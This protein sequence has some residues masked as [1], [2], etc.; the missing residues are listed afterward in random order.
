MCSFPSDID[1]SGGSGD[2]GQPMNRSFAIADLLRAAAAA[3]ANYYYPQEAGT[4]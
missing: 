3:P 2:K 1:R 4:S